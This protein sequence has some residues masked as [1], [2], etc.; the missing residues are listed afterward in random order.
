MVLHLYRITA[1]RHAP[2][3]RDHE[4]ATPITGPPLFVLCYALG[5]LP[6]AVEGACRAIRRPSSRRERRPSPRT[7]NANTSALTA[8][9]RYFSASSMAD[10]LLHRAPS[11]ICSGARVTLYCLRYGLY[12][13]GFVVWLISL[14]AGPGNAP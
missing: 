13:D 14:I 6:S 1:I 2:H 11:L 5:S 12:H 7:A 4:S 9:P 3:R 8:P 10:I